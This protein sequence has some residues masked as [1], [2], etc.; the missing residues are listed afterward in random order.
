MEL[1]SMIRDCVC[2]LASL[3]TEREV[4]I[5]GNSITIFLNRHGEPPTRFKK[6]SAIVHHRSASADILANTTRI[7]EERIKVKAEKCWRLKHGGALWLAL[8]NNYWLSDPETY[9]QAL[10]SLSLVHPFSRILLVND[11]GSVVSLTGP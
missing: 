7:L 5:C 2:D 11:D 6:V 4:L 1:G 9:E 10:S 3:A 8:R